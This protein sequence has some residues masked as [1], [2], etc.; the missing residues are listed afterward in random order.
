MVY[1]VAVSP[2]G[3]WVASG[4]RDQSVRIWDT[5]NAVMQCILNHDDSVYAV[6][7]SRAGGY[8]AFGARNGPVRIWKYRA[9]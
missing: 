9:H 7:F 6:D 8:F 5:R 3:R 2:D 1:C 4:S